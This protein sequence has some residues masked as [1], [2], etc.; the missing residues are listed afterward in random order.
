[1]DRALLT[2]D[3][4]QFHT[5]P[6]KPKHSTSFLLFSNWS[7]GPSEKQHNHVSLI[8]VVFASVLGLFIVLS[9]HDCIDKAVAEYDKK[10]FL[11]DA[12]VNH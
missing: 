1:M 8:L 2:L 6:S 10:S 11:L 7:L 3:L 9:R 12:H 4:I 5:A